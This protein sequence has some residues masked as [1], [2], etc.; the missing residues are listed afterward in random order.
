MHHCVPPP[1]ADRVEVTVQA[2][3]PGEPCPTCGHVQPVTNTVA[4]PKPKTVTNK[5][6]T[7]AERQAKW[8][9]ANKA[10]AQA[11][12]KERMRKKRAATKGGT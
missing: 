11:E 2:L 8:R 4:T 3:K 10:K 6:P 7:N 12:A 9:A 5:K 1:K